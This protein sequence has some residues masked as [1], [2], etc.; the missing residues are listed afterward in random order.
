MRT[1]LFLAA[2][3]AASACGYSEAKFENKFEKVFCDKLAECS[4]MSCDGIEREEPVEACD[5]DP[6][7]AKDCI[8]G[9]WTCASFFGMQFPSPPAACGRVYTDCPTDDD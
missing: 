7:A 9:N 3:L 1:T 5:F 8:D 6:S 2:T 4:G